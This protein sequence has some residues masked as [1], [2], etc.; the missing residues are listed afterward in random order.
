MAGN[1]P[2]T[3]SLSKCASITSAFNTDIR[4]RPPSSRLMRTSSKSP[5]RYARPNQDAPSAQ[6]TAQAMFR[7]MD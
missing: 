4:S 6:F 2:A 7:G 3:S 5:V 1:P